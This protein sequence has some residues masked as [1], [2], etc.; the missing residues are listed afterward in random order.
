MEWSYAE[1]A[2][3]AIAKIGNG[4]GEFAELTADTAGKAIAGAEV[5]GSGNDLKLK[6]DYNT[7]TAG[8]YPI[9][10]VTYEIVCSNG[11][12]DDKLPLV[13]SFLS[14]AASADGQADLT[15]LGYAPLPETVRAKVATAVDVPELTARTPGN[16]ASEQ[17]GDPHSRRRRHRRLGPDHV[18][19]TGPP[20]PRRV[21]RQSRPTARPPTGSASAAAA[22]CRGGAPFGAERA[23]RGLTAGRR[24]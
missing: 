6:I 19:R 3:L 9:V 7:K 14:Y 13:K 11:L 21:R 4:A 8:A 18:V 22:P 1:N 12:A 10:L 16:E 5:T 24:R 17:M 2:G 15:D 20:A 23:F